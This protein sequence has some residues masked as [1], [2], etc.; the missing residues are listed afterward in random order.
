MPHLNR[1]EMLGALVLP[2]VAACTGLDPQ[3]A[4]IALAAAPPAR[5][6]PGQ[7]AQDEDFWTEVARAFT[8]DRTLI[9]L[10][11][12]GVAPAP[13][14]VQ[15]T[16]K[17][18]L[19]YANTQPPSLAVLGNHPEI[20]VVRERLARTFG[21]GT[22]EIAL[23]RNASESLLICQNGLDLREG[24]EVLTSTQDYPRMINGFRQR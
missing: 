22:E 5:V 18:W 10:N 17:R 16:V 23:T 8:H 19:D 11:N 1:R 3:R 9:N 12:G 24:D 21:A 2:A 13:R 14:V 20:E 15:E 7:V 6:P 4:R